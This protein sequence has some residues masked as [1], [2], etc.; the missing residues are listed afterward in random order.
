MD[1]DRGFDLDAAG[2]RAGSAD[3]ATGVEVLA[4]KLEGALPAETVVRRRSRGFLSREKVV[5]EIA[6]ALGDW[7]Y[8]VRI[9]GGRVEASRQQTVRGVAIRREALDLDAWIAALT[10]ELREQAATST[11]ARAALERLV[12]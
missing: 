1:E 4:A 3:L 7:R 12:G 2:L 10:G 11:Q 5:E 6:V 9:D 8:A